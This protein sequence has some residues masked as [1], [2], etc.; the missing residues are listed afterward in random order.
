[1]YIQ[2]Y[3]SI[4]VNKTHKSLVWFDYNMTVLWRNIPLF[5][6][7]HITIHNNHHKLI[8]Q[9]KNKY[10]PTPKLGYDQ[11]N[12]YHQLNMEAVQLESNGCMRLCVVRHVKTNKKSRS[13]QQKSSFTIYKT[14]SYFLENP[15]VWSLSIGKR[16]SYIVLCKNIILG[17]I[18]ASYYTKTF[19]Y[20][21]AL[22][23]N[24]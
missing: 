14:E 21:G 13:R 4:L 24:I 11:K 15:K 22:L 18:I 10:L 16:Y 6:Y 8:R 3:S 2:Y 5:Y 12:S 23:L 17:F 9:K 20:T 19:N 7:D 1:M